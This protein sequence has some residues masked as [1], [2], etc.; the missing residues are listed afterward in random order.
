VIINVTGGPDMS[1]M[2]VNDA[3]TII[4]E[5]A[6]EDANIIFGAVVDPTLNGQ[7]KITVIATG[8]A[9]IRASRA[10]ATS[11]SATVTPVDMRSYTTA[12]ANARPAATASAM[13]VTD[14]LLQPRLTIP[15][16]PGLELPPMAP[17]MAAAAAAGGES[18]GHQSR[19]EEFELNMDLDVPAFLRRSEG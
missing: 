18:A 3:L 4:Q 8:F 7:I 19:G 12:V 9:H 11:S 2:E 16:R 1:L 17:R 15:R 14:A 10:V 6:H 5:A 13:A